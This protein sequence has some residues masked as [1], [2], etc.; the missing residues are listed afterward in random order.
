MFLS[1]ARQ[2]YILFS[3]APRRRRHQVVDSIQVSQIAICIQFFLFVLCRPQNGIGIKTWAPFAFNISQ[4][5]IK[6]VLSNS[7]E[8]PNLNSILLS[9]L[10]GYEGAV[11][12]SSNTSLNFTC[13]LA[14][15]LIADPFDNQNLSNTACS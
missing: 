4:T 5:T 7:S 3:V 15:L 6:P 10:I 9:D 12:F 11:I 2:L 13:R 8:N 1:S 14:I